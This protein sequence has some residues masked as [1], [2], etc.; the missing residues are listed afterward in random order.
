MIPVRLHKY[1]RD[2]SGLS[3]RDVERA[4]R[5]GRLRIQGMEQT[6]YLDTLIFEEDVVLLDGVVL[7]CRKPG[8]YLVF[9][10]PE[11]VIT[12]ARDPSGR[13]CLEPWLDRL[14]E[15][16]APV[17]RLDRATSG[18]LIL[19]DDGDLSY[20]LTHPTFQVPKEYHLRIRGQIAP[21]DARLAQLLAGVDIGDGEAIALEL[22]ITGWTRTT[23]SLRMTIDEG[24]NRQ[25]RRMCG[26]VRLPLMHLHRTRVGTLALGAVA[27]GEWRA[28]RAC[29]VEGL[30]GCGNSEL[31]ARERRIEA[32]RRQA[33]SRRGAGEP[34][35][36]LEAWLRGA[37]CGRA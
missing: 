14:P 13:P 20:M 4:W 12:T 6:P 9:H 30:W 3:R 2:S 7:R 35:L 21:E 25:V 24:R 11:G 16:V 36:R 31:G 10:K 27:A 28:M 19:T 33:A 5:A 23:T 22:R 32:L 26:A 34:D 17:G 37:G 1:V 29:E 8:Q 18:L 15:G